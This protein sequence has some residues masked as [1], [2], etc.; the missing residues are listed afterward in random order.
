MNRE[1]KQHNFLRGIVVTEGGDIEYSL[2]VSKRA[3]FIRLVISREGL[4]KVT[5]PFLVNENI[6]EDFI[7]QKSKWIIEK[8]E[9][10]KKNPKVAVQKH[11][12]QEIKEYKT[13][14]LNIVS[15]RLEYWNTFYNFTYNKIT[16]KN[17]K[18]R[19]GSCSKKGNLNFNYKIVL[20]PQKLADYIIVHELCHLG[21]MNHSSKFW[22][23]V[24]KT[25]P[26]HKEL[27]KQ[28]KSI[29]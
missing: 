6:A 14:A 28:L 7:I 13:Q 24:S 21:E 27:R 29:V 17:T 4:L 11:T 26:D 15:S 12:K 8:M 19:W 1:E 18:S 25:I 9:N 3:K 2:S 16:I 22:T 20:L 5:I 10:A 23:L